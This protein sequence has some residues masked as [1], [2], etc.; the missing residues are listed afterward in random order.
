MDPKVEEL[1]ADAVMGRASRGL[2]DRMPA[3]DQTDPLAWHRDLTT[4]TA[5]LPRLD[6]A[7]V[8]HLPPLMATCLYSLAE[9]QARASIAP[10]DVQELL[11][12][13]AK[14][15]TATLGGVEA[16][17]IQPEHPSGRGR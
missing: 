17:G 9:V 7:V 10:G 8:A 3:A 12:Q 5:E 16:T 11:N 13:W 14:E 4:A 6:P 15:Q 1:A 2:A